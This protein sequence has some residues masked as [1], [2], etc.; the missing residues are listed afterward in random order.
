M[1]FADSLIA[2]LGAKTVDSIDV[3]DYEGA[4]VLFDM[5][6]PIPD[7]LKGKYDALVDG[8]TLEHIFFFPTALKNCM[9]M[10]KVGGHLIFLTP[11]NNWFGHGF[12][13][14]S[15][16]LFYR[17]LCAENGYE[18]ERVVALEEEIA[19]RG[20]GDK[21]KVLVL[22]SPWF[23]IPDPAAVHR[24]TQLVNGR[25]V[26][27][28]IVAK[29][30]ADV[31][32]FQAPPQQSDYTVA[33]DKSSESGAEKRPESVSQFE[34]VRRR[35]KRIKIKF[36]KPKAMIFRKQRRKMSWSG[37]RESFVPYKRRRK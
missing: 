16:E 1:P 25:S 28:F 26:L 8:G 11:A 5:N 17:A 10:V 15:P 14:F 3:S 9:E 23:E 22:N 20:D 2:A 19:V 24:R 37:D 36:P 29:R 4:T 30:V 18:V 7:T 6:Y 32:M 21:A 35:L 13:Q 34:A 33:W 12:Y 27:L 31:P